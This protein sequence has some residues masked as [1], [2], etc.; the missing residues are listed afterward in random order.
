MRDAL[1]VEHLVVRSNPHEH[2]NPG[3][4]RLEVVLR[5][6]VGLVE[7]VSGRL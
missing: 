7:F 6:E 3:A 2:E 5:S 4:G 1:D